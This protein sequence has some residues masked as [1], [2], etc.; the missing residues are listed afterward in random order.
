MNS[1]AEA[2]RIGATT[3]T[4]STSLPQAPQSILR[5]GVCPLRKTVR[6]T[7]ET[8]FTRGTQRTTALKAAATHWPATA[9]TNA[10][11]TSSAP[12]TYAAALDSGATTSCFPSTFQGTHYTPITQP[13]DAILAQAADDQIIMTSVARDQL[14]EPHLPPACWVVHLFNEIS[15]PLLSVNKLCAGDLAVLFHGPTATVFKPSTNT[16]TIDGEPVMV[17]TL[18][19]ETELYMV[20]VNGTNNLTAPYKLHGGTSHLKVPVSQTITTVSLHFTGPTALL[21]GQYQP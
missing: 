1:I 9:V 2:R 16:V 18:D 11:T 13:Q 6:F 10:P 15:I 17:G 12:T 20:Q 7:K 3:T 4:S 19:K 8:K 21:S 5:Q 14:N